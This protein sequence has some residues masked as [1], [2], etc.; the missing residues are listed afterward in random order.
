[1]NFN[2]EFH[3]FGPMQAFEKLLLIS[4]MSFARKAFEKQY[5]TILE[6]VANDM[7]H[8]SSAC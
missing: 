4:G 2:R 8:E 5:V 6:S 1:M 3:N 7:F